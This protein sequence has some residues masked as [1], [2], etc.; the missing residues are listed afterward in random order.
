MPNTDPKTADRM[1]EALELVAAN[2]EDQ[3]DRA[4]A[5]ICS[6]VKLLG[7]DAGALAE[8]VEQDGSDA[9]D[10]AFVEVHVRELVQAHAELA[11]RRERLREIHGVI[12][13]AGRAAAGKRGRAKPAARGS[14][15]ESVKYRH[16]ERRCGTRSCGSRCRST[17]ISSWST[18]RTCWGCCRIRPCPGPSSS[19]SRHPRH[20][21]GH[22]SALLRPGG[23]FVPR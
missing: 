14:R 1:R 13:F 12:E 21:E 20:Q 11:E 9:V 10:A 8:R 16:G 17:P 4:R 18:W 7:A 3:V 2:F 15:S 6:L 19:P 5:R 23:W 22:F